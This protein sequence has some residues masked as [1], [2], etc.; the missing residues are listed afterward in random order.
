MVTGKIA[1]PPHIDIRELQR[2]LDAKLA[3]VPDATLLAPALSE[4]AR[5]LKRAEV[6]RRRCDMLRSSLST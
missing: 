1:A 2:Q 5:D 6:E 4:A 3:R